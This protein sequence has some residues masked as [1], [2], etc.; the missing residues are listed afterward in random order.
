MSN[1]SYVE[2]ITPDGKCA[3]HNETLTEFISVDGSIDLDCAQCYHEHPNSI[4]DR[5]ISACLKSSEEDLE[6][7]N[8]IGFTD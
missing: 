3:R 1:H 7:V 2:L 4:V 6:D 8:D 5:D